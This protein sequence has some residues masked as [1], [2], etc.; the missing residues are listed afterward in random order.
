VA[1]RRVGPAEIEEILIEHPAVSE[2]AIIGV[3]HEIKGEEIVAFAILNP[4]YQPTEELRKE[5][6]DYVIGKLGK[7]L[8]PAELKFVKA[9]PKTRTAKI[10]RGVIKAKYLGKKDLGDLTSVENLEAIHEI[11]KAT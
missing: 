7:T 9:L 8:R 5:L 6:K 3:P 2:A 11:E 1:G 4:K 10:V